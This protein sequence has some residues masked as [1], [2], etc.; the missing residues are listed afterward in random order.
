M[1]CPSTTTHTPGEEGT[2]SYTLPFPINSLSHVDL[3]PD[4][5]SRGST[6]DA[7]FRRLHRLDGRF[8]PPSRRFLHQQT[9]EAL[10]CQVGESFPVR[11]LSEEAPWRST[12][13]SS[14]LPL[15]LRASVQA[16]PPSFFNFSFPSAQTPLIS[17]CRYLLQMF[18]A[19]IL[20]GILNLM[21]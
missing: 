14:S 11:Y 13:L 2:S 10:D 7:V 21:L 8:L 18:L 6:E 5:P 12:S 3:L 16:R 20:N 1:S 15:I 17:S 19:L 4:E 9:Q